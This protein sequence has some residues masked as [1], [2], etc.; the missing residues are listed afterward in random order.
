VYWF[1]RRWLSFS[2][3]RF[4][5][6]LGDEIGRDTSARGFVRRETLQAAAEYKSRVFTPGFLRFKA[7]HCVFLDGAPDMF[8]D[9]QS[10]E[11]DRNALECGV[12]LIE[13]LKVERG[14]SRG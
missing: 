1:W 12:S 4:S 6:G 14:S 7:R 8:T 10:T 9:A 2:F 11:I 5:G 13:P 3:Q